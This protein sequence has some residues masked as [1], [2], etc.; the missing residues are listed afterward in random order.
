L[1]CTKL[2]RQ[3]LERKEV[4]KNEEVREVCNLDA[5]VNQMR[6]SDD[7]R[8][9]MNVELYGHRANQ[10]F[11]SSIELLLPESVMLPYMIYIQLILQLNFKCSKEH[12]TVSNIRAVSSKRVPYRERPIQLYQKDGN[13]AM[14]SLVTVIAVA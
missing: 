7:G 13:P 3:Y 4:N 11:V 9:I 5:R 6:M 12:I 2:L 8:I 10:P 1:Q 14:M